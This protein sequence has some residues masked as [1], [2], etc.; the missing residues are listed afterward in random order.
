MDSPDWNDEWD[1]DDALLEG[2]METLKREA[3][4]NCLFCQLDDMDDE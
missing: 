1:N 4:D 3:P 2:F